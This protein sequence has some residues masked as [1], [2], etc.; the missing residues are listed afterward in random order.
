M[1]SKTTLFEETFKELLQKLVTSEQVDETNWQGQLFREA[2]FEIQNQMEMEDLEGS[3]EKH[4]IRWNAF[5][6]NICKT[7]RFEG[8]QEF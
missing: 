1:Q 3:T 8:R 4:H 2:E 7:G 6:S 5:E